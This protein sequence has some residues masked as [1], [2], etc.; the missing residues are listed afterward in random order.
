MG[1]GVGHS[2]QRCV[3]GTLPSRHRTYSR[4]FVCTNEQKETILKC[5]QKQREIKP[6]Q[7][8]V[9]P[10]PPPPPRADAA[11]TVAVDRP[12]GLWPS[13]LPNSTTQGGSHQP[14]VT[15]G[16]VKYGS[17]DRGSKLSILFNFNE[18]TFKWPQVASGYALGQRRS[19]S[20]WD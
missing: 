3:P 12:L 16:L 2:V 13:H 14:R 15:T 4:V 20:S 1:A 6:P 8:S 18:F 17:C 9:S 11:L 7:E 10:S 19:V 5:T